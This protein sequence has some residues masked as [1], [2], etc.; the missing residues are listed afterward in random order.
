M[1]RIACIGT[2]QPLQHTELLERIGTFLA[3]AGY[4][5]STGNAV[6]SD[7]AFARGA[8]SVNPAQVELWLP[9]YSYERQAIVHGNQVHPGPQQWAY[10]LAEEH[11]PNWAAC[12]RGAT[13]LHARNCHIVKGCTLCIALP[14]ATRLGGTG[15]GMRV[16]EA[17]GIPILNLRKP[18]DL[19]R[20]LAKL[21]C[22]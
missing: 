14:G 3:A 18:E 20:V 4:V 16:A 8:N 17:L 6:G 19:E 2:R 1:K 9:W 15:Q 13:A 12:S 5:I 11:H 10:K 21:G 7:Q 22:F